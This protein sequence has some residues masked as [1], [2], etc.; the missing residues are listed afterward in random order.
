MALPAARFARIRGGVVWIVHDTVSDAMQRM[1]IA[2]G[3]GAVTRA[4]AVSPPTAKSVEPLGVHALVAPLGVDIPPARPTMSAKEPPVVGIMG[5]ITPWKGHRTLLQAVAKLATVRCEIAGSAFHAD[6]GYF[7]ELNQLIAEL[8]LSDRVTF[9][10]HVDPL[11]TIARW[12]LLIS[13]S[14]S[15]EAGPIVALEAMSLG[16]PVI[17]S[18]HGGSSWILRD[19][20]GVLVPPGDAEALAKAIEDALDDSVSMSAIAGRARERVLADHDAAV[21]FPAMLDTVLGAPVK[22]GR[23]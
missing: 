15:P 8:S 20:A 2:L 6:Q 16:V 7:D 17:A 23:P 18:D 3:R 10:G 14:T 22:V 9:L 1:V 5:A 21:A 19:G 11:P 4:V 12:D 13:A